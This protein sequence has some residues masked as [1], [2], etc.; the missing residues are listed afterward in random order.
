MIKAKKVLLIL[1]VATFVIID[2]KIA[3]TILQKL[4]NNIKGISV[5][6]I[7]RSNLEYPKTESK[8][9]YFY[10]PKNNEI[11]KWHPDWLGYEV[12][13]KINSDSLN[14]TIEY[15]IEKP[16]RYF[17]III[18]GDSNVYGLFVETAFNFP[19]RLEVLLNEKLT[20]KSISHFDVINMGVAGYDLEYSVERFI[21]R[22]LK[23]NPDLL[24]WMV[25]EWNFQNI[26]EFTL[27]LQNKYQ[28]MEVKEFDSASKK[29]VFVEQAI[30]EL[31]KKFS[32]NEIIGY[33]QKIIERLL[34]RYNGKILFL[35]Y[36]DIPKIYSNVIYSYSNNDKYQYLDSLTNLLKD[37]NY[38][39]LD[40]HPNKL[41]YQKISEEIL[42]FISKN[43]LND[44]AN[45][46]R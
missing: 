14:E 42:D 25:N 33:Q 9:K 20:C 11:Q 35:S 17:R 29:F 1:L 28:N 2:I 38:H 3:V 22:G 40:F 5:T 18:I 36:S 21:N 30:N 26:N 31:H 12:T 27:S 44:C 6:R 13:N 16:E 15:Q 46:N 19:E 4:I 24:I 7:D 34:R 41:G 10:E 39:Y 37:S 45:F 8:L 23:Y 32:Q 43:Y